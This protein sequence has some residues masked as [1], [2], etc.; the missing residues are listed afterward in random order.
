MSRSNNDR[1]FTAIQAK[2][3]FVHDNDVWD[4]VELPDN[5]KSIGC[6]WVSKSKK[7]SNATL[8]SLKPGLLVRGF[9]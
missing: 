4:L 2:L 1:W 3:K 5:L 9:T 8:I 7:D 6:K